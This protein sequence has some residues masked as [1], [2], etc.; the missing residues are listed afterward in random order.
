MTASAIEA[1]FIEPPIISLERAVQ[2]ARDELDA[3]E[4]DRAQ[5]VTL[6]DAHTSRLERLR[7]THAPMSEIVETRSQLSAARELL[8][9]Q[10]QAI[11]EAKAALETARIALDAE[12]RLMV[13]ERCATALQTTRDDLEAITLEIRDA[14]EAYRPRLV[15]L[16]R[17]WN[18]SRLEYANAANPSGAGGDRGTDALLAFDA[19]LEARGVPSNAIHL[20]RL[21]VFGIAA[22]TRNWSHL[23]NARLEFLDANAL[24]HLA[25]VLDALAHAPE[26]PEVSP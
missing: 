20:A 19:T 15:S 23:S 16:W 24:P 6:E 14:L 3:L 21:D 22:G 11:S 9:E 8:T 25:F 7:E 18:T 2:D 12:E 17:T 26:H 5:L 4:R 1:P 13:G 10:D